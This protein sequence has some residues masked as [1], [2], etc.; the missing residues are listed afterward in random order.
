MKMDENTKIVAKNTVLV[1]A[2]AVLC[3][4]TSSGWPGFGLIFWDEA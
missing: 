3:W 1:I 4:I 2:I